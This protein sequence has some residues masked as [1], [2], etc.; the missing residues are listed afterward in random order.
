MLKGFNSLVPPSETATILPAELEIILS[1]QRVIDIAFI[2]RK[3][4]YSGYSSGS[5]QVKWLWKVLTK[6]SPDEK[7]KFLQFATGSG[8][9]PIREVESW[10]FWVKKGSEG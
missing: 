10:E 7:S 2:R 4:K 3:T 6:F 8:C 5:K 9:L 1:G